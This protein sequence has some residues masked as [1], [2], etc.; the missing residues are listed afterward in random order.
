MFATMLAL[1][2]S[3]SLLATEVHAQWEKRYQLP[4]GSNTRLVYIKPNT[5]LMWTL[6][7]NILKRS[8]DGGNTFSNVESFADLWAAGLH[9]GKV[10]FVAEKGP[11]DKPTL[12]VSTDDGASF[13]PVSEL[14]LGMFSP[15]V[16]SVLSRNGKLF[17]VST[18]KDILHSSDNG[19]TWTRY[20]LPDSMG[21]NSSFDIHGTT[22]AVTTN[23]GAYLS[24]D[25]GATWQ[26]LPKGANN[27]GLGI[28]LFVGG[29]L[30]GATYVDVAA[31]RGSEWESVKLPIDKPGYYAGA[32]DLQTDGKNLYVAAEGMTSGTG[33]FVLNGNRFDSVGFASYPAMHLFPRMLCIGDTEIYV[34]YHLLVGGEGNVY[35]HPKPEPTSVA[36]ETAMTSA[37]RLWPNPT[38]DAITV[39]ADPTLEVS[40]LSYLGE[41]LRL[42]ISRNDHHA[43]IDLSSLPTGM[44]L[45]RVGTTTATVVK[46]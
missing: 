20:E 38:T 3:I 10:Y 12:Y 45:V 28:I 32:R 11:L 26:K 44:Y 39:A 1:V 17:V 36:D 8:T 14:P 41:R 30:Y 29:Q 15:Y 24:P 34:A 5:L 21:V 4:T 19:A 42:P 9:D 46:Q 40:V 16:R 6:G 33:V 27:L 37:P 25:E 23:V 13:T 35:A 31:W 7:L 43:A 18:T 22:W 2:M